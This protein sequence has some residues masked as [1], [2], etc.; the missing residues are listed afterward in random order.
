MKTATGTRRARR[1]AKA[2]GRM[3]ESEA[4]VLGL[5]QRRVPKATGRTG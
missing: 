4:V 3:T 1:T 5:L 2:V